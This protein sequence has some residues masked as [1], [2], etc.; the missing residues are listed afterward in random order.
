MK[1]QKSTE[2]DFSI[3]VEDILPLLDKVKKTGREWTALCPAHDDHRNSLAIGQTAEGKALLHCF[4]GCSYLD[5]ITSV[6]LYQEPVEPSKREIVAEYDY[7]NE[8]ADLIYQVIRYHPKAFAQ[9]RP[10]GNGGWIYNLKGVPKLLYNLLELINTE[11]DYVFVTEGEKS[12]DDLKALGFVATSNSGGAGKWD[13]SFNKYFKGKDVVIFPDNDDAGFEHAQTVAKNLYPVA[14]SVRII[15]LEGLAPKQDISDWIAKDVEDSVG[16]LKALI[17]T[18]EP[19]KYEEEELEFDDSLPAYVDGETFIL[20]AILNNQKLLS[21]AID[22]KLLQDFYGLKNKSILKAMLDCFEEKQGIDIITVGEKLKQLGKLDYVGGLAHLKE[23]K[24][25]VTDYVNFD[26]WVSIVASKADFRRYI[27]LSDKL[28]LAAAR[29]TESPK[30]IG[31]AVAKE[32]YKINSGKQKESFTKVHEPVAS[33]LATARAQGHTGLAGISTGYK[34]LDDITSGLN[35]TDLFILAARPSMGKTSLALNIAYNVSTTRN[36]AF[37]SLEMSKDQ[38]I[39]RVLCSE[40]RVNSTDFKTGNLTPPEWGRLAET[41][42][43]LERSNLYINDS[44]AMSVMEIRNEA[45]KLA[46]QIGTLDLIV[47]DYLQLMRQGNR[48]SRFQEVSE[49][50]RELKGLAKELDVPVIALSQLSRSCESRTPPKP[51][52]SDL[53]ES[54]EIEQAADVV[55]FIY[56]DEYYYPTKQDNVGMADIILA[57]QRNGPP[58]TVNLAYIGKYTRFENLLRYEPKILGHGN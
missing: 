8:E 11:A 15:T 28:R 53:R 50:A 45:H 9:R 49:I 29:E 34:D 46:E 16:T 25:E 54:G 18:Q 14:S 1:I 43:L 33:I 31:D 13:K 12:V 56:R 40:A 44:P 57:K 7:Y 4:K 51:I 35:K 20:G 6:G 38:L 23:L 10:D 21:K 52:M 5:I 48:E 17:E 42:P 32:L 58:G 22:A 36:V 3:Y 47:I 37:F 2:Q 24:A 41:A 39:K 26:S 30:S 19:V 27:K 55:A